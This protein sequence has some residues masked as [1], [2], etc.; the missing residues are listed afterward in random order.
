MPAA[1]VT[2]RLGAAR[3][4]ALGLSAAASG[5]SLLALAPGLAA[6]LT[7]RVLFGVGGAIA[8]T[9]AIALL[10]SIGDDATRSAAFAGLGG[11]VAGGFA[12]GALLAAVPA[13]RI[14]V[15]FS[16]AVAVAAGL[17]A[18]RLP[19]AT[20]GPRRDLRGAPLLSAAIVAAA[21]GIVGVD[22]AVAWAAVTFAA[23]AILATWA[24]RSAAPW[25]PP[26]RSALAAVCAAGAATTA[27]GV[28]ATILIGAALAERGLPTALLCVF[29]AGVVPGAA[30]AARAGPP[31]AL[32]VGLALQ[33]VALGL[34]APALDLGPAARALARRARIAGRARLTARHVQDAVACWSRDARGPRPT[35]PG[36]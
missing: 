26:H 33:A 27:S 17:V 16:A 18:A 5:A 20:P 1:A 9:A 36:P 34:V 19:D 31:V 24:V 15:L 10:A 23:A 4:L 7:G 3:T 35:A 32:G 8:A 13:W 21:V 6:A 22:D 12:T 25:L 2:G 28:G 29:A 11:A 14:V 30:P